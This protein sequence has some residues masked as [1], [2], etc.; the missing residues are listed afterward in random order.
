M[1]VVVVGMMLMMMD[2]EGKGCCSAETCWKY[3]V[4]FKGSLDKADW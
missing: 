2:G 4:F 3:E 1:G